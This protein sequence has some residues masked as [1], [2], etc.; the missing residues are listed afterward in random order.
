LFLRVSL[1]VFRPAKIDPTDTRAMTT[2]RYS[3]LNDSMMRIREDTCYV[4]TSI[5]TDF[6]HETGPCDVTGV[7]LT[8]L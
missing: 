6:Q 8:E 4:A 1:A 2:N 3:I 7:L 5:P